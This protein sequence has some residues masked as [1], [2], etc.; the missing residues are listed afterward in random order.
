MKKIGIMMLLVWIVL[1]SGCTSHKEL[2]SPSLKAFQEQVSQAIPEI[3][4]LKTVALPTR[5]VFRYTFETKPDLSVQQDIV[6]RT[7]SYMRTENFETEVL[8]SYYEAFSKEDRLP[9]DIV[10]AMDTDENGEANFE[11]Y[12]PFQQDGEWTWSYSDYQNKA[13]EVTLP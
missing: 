12:A 4:F 6:K 10:V 7:D 11:Y 13:E 2:N 1:L 8:A 3:K 9:P 5:V